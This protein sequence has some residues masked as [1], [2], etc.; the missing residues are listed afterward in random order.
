M[1]QT[2]P[3]TVTVTD[4]R[5][6]N[7]GKLMINPWVLDLF[8]G[9]NPVKFYDIATW[10]K[11]NSVSEVYQNEAPVELPLAEYLKDIQVMMKQKMKHLFLITDM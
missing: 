4:P 1:W 5:G 2:V 11:Y 9:D 7:D 6:G 10:D 3:I 8:T